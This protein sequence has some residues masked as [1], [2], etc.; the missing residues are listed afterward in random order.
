MTEN[1]DLR[2]F[3][4]LFSEKMKKIGSKISVIDPSNP[5]LLKLKEKSASIGLTTFKGVKVEILEIYK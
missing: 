3:D 4:D 1:R 2:F 5:S